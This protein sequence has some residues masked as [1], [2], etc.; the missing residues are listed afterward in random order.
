MES[1]GYTVQ[2]LTRQYC[3]TRLALAG[4]QAL[5]EDLRVESTPLRTLADTILDDC[6]LATRPEVTR[7]FARRFLR[8]LSSFSAGVVTISTASIRSWAQS[9]GC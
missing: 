4:D 3:V 9:E 1:T 2:K 7:A 6:G 8:P 5:V